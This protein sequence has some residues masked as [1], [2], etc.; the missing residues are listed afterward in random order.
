M[1]QRTGQ[2]PGP[3]ERYDLKLLEESIYADKNWHDVDCTHPD[4]RHRWAAPVIHIMPGLHSASPRHYYAVPGRDVHA[5]LVFC[6]VCGISAPVT[7]KAK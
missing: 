5:G 7:E 2:Q 1:Q 6:R 3:D 4:K